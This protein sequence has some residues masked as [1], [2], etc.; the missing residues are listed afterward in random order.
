MDD[1]SRVA[2]D[3]VL[4]MLLSACVLQE[5]FQLAASTRHHAELAA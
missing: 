4:M 2:I 1:G 5:G 3:Q